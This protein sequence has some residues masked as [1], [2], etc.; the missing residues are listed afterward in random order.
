MEKKIIL[1]YN[2]PKWHKDTLR[3]LQ[4][5]PGNYII[6]CDRSL[7][8]KADVVIFHLFDLYWHMTDDIEKKI[9]SY[10]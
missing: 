4:K 1:F 10:G 6:T 8:D 2:N 9:A 3:E 7:F 5:I